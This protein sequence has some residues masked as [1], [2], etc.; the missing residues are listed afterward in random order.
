MRPGLFHTQ[1]EHVAEVGSANEGASTSGPAACSRCGT[2]PPPDTNFCPRCGNDLR[3][4]TAEGDTFRGILPGTIIDGRYRMLEKLGEGAMGS[5][6]KVEHVRM[7]KLLALTVLKADLALQPAVLA[8]FRDEARIVSKLSHPNTISVFDFGELE[9]GSLYIAMELV[10]GRDL[11]RVLLAEGRLPERR[12][13]ALAVQILRSLEEAHEAGIVHRDIKP[14]NVMVLSTR[15]GEDWAKVVDFGIAKLSEA[16]TARKGEDEKAI[17]GVAEFVG[18]PN[19]CAPEQ[20]R[21][22]LL[23][24]RTDLYSLGAMLFEL[25]TGKAPFEAPGAVQVIARHLSE[26]P[27]HPRSRVSELSTELDAIV[28]KALAKDP[29]ERFQSAGHMRDALEALIGAQAKTFAGE[30][31]PIIDGYEVASREDWEG[32]EKSLARGTRLR[33]AFGVLLIGGLFAAAGLFAYHRVNAPRVDLPLAEE[34]E[35][36]LIALDAPVT[37]SMGESHTAGRSDLDT[38]RLELSTPGRLTVALTGVTDLNLVLEL[39]DAEKEAQHLPD[40]LTH[41]TIDDGQLGAGELLTDIP[42]HPGRYFL[43]VSERPAYDEPDPARPP[44]ERAGARYTLTAHVDALSA[45]DELEP[46][47]LWALAQPLGAGHPVLGHAGARIANPSQLLARELV[48]SA[49]DYYRAEVPRSAVALLVPPPTRALG[50]YDAMTV[51]TLRAAS[52]VLATKRKELLRRLQAGE[53][54]ANRELTR[55]APPV[56]PPPT[57]ANAAGIVVQRLSAT[58][59]TVGVLVVPLTGEEPQAGEAPYGLVIAHAGPGG[60]EGVLVLADALAERNRK[61]AARALVAQ[62]LAELPG[63]EDVAKLRQHLALLR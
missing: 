28:V 20:A 35:P 24:A 47:D 49:L 13:V 39:F 46:N 54:T 60:I 10:K 11:A 15:G 37:G 30:A 55:L 59:G 29:A 41:V 42:V 58:A 18:T 40:P 4:A 62:A 51:E 17:T 3:G 31:L 45:L 50:L 61:E 34:H 6:F 16:Q 21:G 27:P 52:A 25:V 43:R 57:R 1:D 14:A 2:S 23:D 5:V 22:Q 38:Y 63:A 44:R 26:P 48:L 32:F 12:A 7:G 19:Y 9:G 53:A 36:N 56:Y 33:A 8:R